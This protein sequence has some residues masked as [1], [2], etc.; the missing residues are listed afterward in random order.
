MEKSTDQI[1]QDKL[2]AISD[3]LEVPVQFAANEAD[4]NVVRPAYNPDAIISKLLALLV[5]SGIS[6]P[7]TFAP[8]YN[9]VH[10]DIEF[11]KKYMAKI[12]KPALSEASASVEEKPAEPAHPETLAE[13]KPSGTEQPQ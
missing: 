9:R 2:T 6:V 4:A 8:G 3:A 1:V 12:I 7:S 13:E 10:A 11:W 5:F